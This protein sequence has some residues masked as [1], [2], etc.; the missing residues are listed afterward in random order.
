MANTELKIINLKP[1]MK[2]ISGLRFNMLEAI[3]PTNERRGNNVIWLCKCDCGKDVYVRQG[4]FIRGNHQSCGCSKNTFISEKRTLSPGEAAFNYV[5]CRYKTMAKRRLLCFDLT[6]EEF[7]TLTSNNCYYCNREPSQ[8]T[9]YKVRGSGEYIYNGVDRID[10]NI[11]Y[12]IDNCVPCCKYC[13]FAK[14][15][16]TFEEFKSWISKIYRNFAENGWL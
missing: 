16:M 11:G 8:I 7:M 1:R 4:D 2:D 9:H 14:N 12:T 6:K 5:Y 15:E 3:S 10:S 13:N